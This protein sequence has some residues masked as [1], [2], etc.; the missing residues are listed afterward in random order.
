M[1]ITSHTTVIPVTKQNDR[2]IIR[3]AMIEVAMIEVAMIEEAMIVVA[4]ENKILVLKNNEVE[5][6]LE[7]AIPNLR[8]MLVHI[9]NVRRIIKEKLIMKS[10]HMLLQE[11][12]EVLAQEMTTNSLRTQEH[13]NQAMVPHQI[14]MV[15]K[16]DPQPNT[17]API[18]KMAQITIQ[19]RQLIPVSEKAAMVGT[20]LKVTKKVA[21]PLL[22]TLEK[23]EPE[24][25]TGIQEAANTTTKAFTTTRTNLLSIHKASSSTPKA[26]M[27]SVASTMSRTSIWPRPNVIVNN[28]TQA[29]LILMIIGIEEKYVHLP[30]RN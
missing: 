3:E 1:V 12:K 19:T 28:E 6:Q 2:L 11:I 17:A 26:L 4:L 15:L 21:T 14:Q 22:L 13:H 30:T 10:H 18:P 25:Q 24:Q 16:V 5:I 9:M 8:T 27:N 29:T 23:E 20:H 7:V